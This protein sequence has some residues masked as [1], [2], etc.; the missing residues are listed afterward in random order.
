VL[1]LHG[2]NLNTLGKRMPE[3]YGRA[4]LKQINDMVRARGEELGCEVVAQQSNHEGQ[5]IDWLQVWAP[6]CDG[7]LI[8]PG[9]LAHYGLALRDALE[10]LDIP[11][12]EVHLS[13]VHAR[14]EWRRTS[15]VAPV[16]LGQVVGF[17]PRGYV[18]GLELLVAYARER[19]PDVG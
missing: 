3:V 17:G 16:T 15:V 9:A 13:N 5:L 14:E 6:E 8:N 19:R 18:A 1:L 12:V 7:V 4:T 11:V 10:A 2:P